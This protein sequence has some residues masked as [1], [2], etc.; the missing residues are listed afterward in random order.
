MENLS[1]E[2]KEIARFADIIKKSAE[3]VVN[4]IP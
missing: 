1:L 2:L 3:K 4:S